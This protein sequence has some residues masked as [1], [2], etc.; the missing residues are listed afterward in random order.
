MGIIAGVTIAA[1]ASM[2]L[3]NAYAT[4]LYANFNIELWFLNEYLDFS[5]IV[6]EYMTL[7]LAFSGLFLA[8]WYRRRLYDAAAQARRRAEL[9][10]ASAAT[11]ASLPIGAADPGT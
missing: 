9:Y 1:V 6:L 3:I 8:W 5:L 11:N 10:A 7:F 2:W 4:D